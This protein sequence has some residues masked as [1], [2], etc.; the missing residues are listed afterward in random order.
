MLCRIFFWL[1]AALYGLALA[2][3]IIGTFGLFS[4]ESDPL[5]G[6]FLIPLGMPWTFLVDLAP[7]PLWPW[8]GALAPAINLY[9]IAMLCR[10]FKKA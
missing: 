4:Q 3:L 10:R 7:E 6:I 8:L 9:L 2:L 1:F 5:S